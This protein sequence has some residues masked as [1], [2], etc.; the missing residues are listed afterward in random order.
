MEGLSRMKEFDFG[1]GMF[2]VNSRHKWRYPLGTWMYVCRVR[3]E[4]WA[5][6]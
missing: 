5:R 4:V 3:G 6:G 1:S 2:E